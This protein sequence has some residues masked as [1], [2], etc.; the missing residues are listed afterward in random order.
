MDREIGDLAQ[1]YVLLRFES[2]RGVN[3]DLFEFDYDV[4]WM[5]FFLTAD[6]R[7]LGR[8]GGRDQHAASK[9]LSIPALRYAMTAALNRYR[10]LP[11]DRPAFRLLEPT[12]PER[13]RAALE[14]SPRSCIHCHHV[15]EF[16]R[17]ELQEMG[18]WRVEASTSIPCPK[19]WASACRSIRGTGCGKVQPGSPASLSGLR[20][21]DELRIVNEW[22]VASFADLQHALH[23]APKTGTLAMVW[24]RDGKTHRGSLTLSEGWRK[25]D[26][27]WRWSLQS[28][29]PAPGVRG[30][31]LSPEE[32][33]SLGLGP[34]RL[35]FRQGNFA[36][37]EA[38]QAGVCQNDI[39]FGIDQKV[40]N[41]TA[42]Q[43]DTYVRINC[44]P[45]QVIVFN[46]LRR[47]PAHRP[48]H[49]TARV[50]ADLVKS[51]Q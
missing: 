32:K 2:M 16:R 20:A 31:D 37:R 22:H 6:E 42:R 8:F 50:I 5:G 23:R 12:R 29:Q 51:R 1:Q 41:M 15:H 34:E 38:R 24:M 33:K 44:R 45:G 25:T 10:G 48:T 36:S 28:L 4:T 46:I 47:R 39:I 26:L 27:S 18:C 40:L 3:L 21:G 49:A 17:R 7:I 30:E 14:R 13:Y 19:T 11:R 35:A 9:Y 43:F